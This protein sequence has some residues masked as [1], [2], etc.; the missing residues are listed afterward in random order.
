MTGVRVE[1]IAVHADARGSL[2]KLLPGPV[3][4][5]V[6]LVRAAPGQSRGHHRHGRMGEWFTAL[7]GEVV[8]GLFDP[9]SGERRYLGLAG[10]RVYV[11][12]GL[13]HALFNT[14]AEDCVILA[15]ADRLHDPQDVEPCDVPPPPTP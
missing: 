10:V 1:P 5:E 3:G 4:G 13:A 15:L 14:G 6:Y 8:L 12:A 7:A 11:P 9:H 2:H